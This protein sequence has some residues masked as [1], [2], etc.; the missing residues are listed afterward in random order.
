MNSQTVRRIRGF[1]LITADLPRLARFY[2]EVLG[3]APDGDA[4]PIP[5]EE[6]AVLALPG[7]GERQRLRLGAQSLALER[8]DTPGRPMPARGT[9]ASLW[10]QHLALIVPDI[11][12]AY[13]RLRDMTPISLNGPQHLPPPTGSVTA[14]KFR[15]PDGHPLELLQF[16]AADVPQAWQGRRAAPGQIALGIDHSA[17]SVA[18]PETSIAYY[19]A[20]GLTQGKRTLNT[21]PAQQRLDD[22]PDVAVDVIPMQ[23]PASPPHLELLAYRTPL[24]DAGPALRPNDIAATRIVWHGLR[25]GLIADP[26]GHLHQIE[27]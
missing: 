3:C 25:T 1:R 16:P 4:Q 7:R 26:D 10:F 2:R 17:I 14:F 24:G 6:M 27:P 8:F 9:A 18:D 12:A 23:P 13:A 11:A 20:L 19:Q 21:G 15:D 5:A 22:L